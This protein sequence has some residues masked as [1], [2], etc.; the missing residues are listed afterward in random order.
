MTR[1]N[2]RCVGRESR[3]PMCLWFLIRLLAL[4]YHF[5]EISRNPRNIFLCEAKEKYSAYMRAVNSP[6]R[7]PLGRMVDVFCWWC[8]QNP[9]K[10][11]SLF[12]LSLANAFYGRSIYSWLLKGHLNLCRVC[13]RAVL[14]FYSV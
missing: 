5:G 13:G 7:G 10:R 1:C 2:Q 6:V 14:L 12:L 9:I 3:K 11:F 4:T 8:I